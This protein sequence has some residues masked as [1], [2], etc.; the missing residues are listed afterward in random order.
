MTKPPNR[1]LIESALI[2][3]ELGVDA[4]ELLDEA[5]KDLGTGRHERI[6]PGA[7]AWAIEKLRQDVVSLREVAG[8]RSPSPTDERAAS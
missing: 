6:A 1:T 4:L 8:R 7:L 5:R 2:D 3:I